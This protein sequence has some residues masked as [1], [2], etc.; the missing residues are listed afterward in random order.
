[1]SILINTF[2]KNKPL[3]ILFRKGEFQGMKA[4]L[5]GISHLKEKMLKKQAAFAYQD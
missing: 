1:L 2:S 5:K 3:L 4:S